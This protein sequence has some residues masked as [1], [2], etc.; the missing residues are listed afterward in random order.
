MNRDKAGELVARG[1]KLLDKGDFKGAAKAFAAALEKEDVV[2][3]RNNLA[4]SLFHSGDP[5]RALEVI[6]P[7]LNTDEEYKRANPFTYALASQIFFAQG[8]GEEARQWLKKAVQSFDAGLAEFYR[9]RSQVPHHFRE[10]T[11]SI[12]RAAAELNDHRQVFEL[13]R[14]WETCHVSWENKFLAGVACFNLGRYK[15]AASLW[16]SISGVYRLFAAMQQ[17]AFM[18]ERGVIPPFAMSYTTYTQEEID[19]I[20]KTCAVDKEARRR[21]WQDGYILMVLLSYILEA[22]ETP[23]A[24]MVAHSLVAYAGEWGEK[25]GW[26]ILESPGFSPTVKMAAAEAFIER[27]LLKEG[28]P[29]RMFI[30]GEN[31]LVHIKKTPVVLGTDKELDAIVE[32]AF[33]L[34]D[35]GQVDA[36]IDLLQDLQQQGKFYPRAMMAL[37]NLLRQKGELAE[38]L[39]IM[40][41]LKEVGPEDPAVLFNYAA[42]MLQMDRIEE[43]RASLEKIAREGLSEEFLQKLELL[44]IELQKREILLNIPEEAIKFYQ[45]EERGQIEAKSLPLDPSLLR[46]LKNMPAHW[47]DGACY[48]YGLKPARLRRER[49]KQLAEHLSSRDNLEKVVGELG[50]GELELLKYLLQRG[51]WSRLNAVSRKFGSLEG[52]GFFWQEQAPRSSLGLLWSKALVMVGKASLE[53]RRVKI[54][55]IPVELRR[56][57]ED[58]LGMQGTGG[59]GK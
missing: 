8:R 16:S 29:V 2:P 21:Y 35:K 48:Q 23:A 12:M 42:L 26:K 22:G 52:D 15:R 25:L 34:R 32:R 47:L 58:I 40:S 27:G 11:V 57:L 5:K 41:M 55:T 18:V 6:Q 54:A 20:I 45:E 36:A 37:A 39:R 51:G 3:I 14:R 13:Y 56:P 30:E 38:A 53:G 33:E 43:A 7:A 9:A 4:L 1:Q 17:V 28:E 31:R 19:A 46:G 10:Y 50:A 59:V 44:E 24:G 49:E